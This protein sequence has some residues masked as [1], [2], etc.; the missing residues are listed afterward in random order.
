MNPLDNVTDV[1]KEAITHIDGPL[2]II[3]AAGSGKTRVITRRIAYLIENGV[4][5]YNILAI[6]FTNKA[7]NEMKER[8]NKFYPH[9]G[10]WVSTFHSMCARILRLEIEKLGYS[11]TFTIYDKQDQVSSIKE[12]IK[13]LAFDI[14]SFSPTKISNAISNAKNNLVSPTEFKE[15]AS[16]YYD[17]VVSQVYLKY[18]ELLKNN[19]ALDFDDLQL[20]VVELFKNFS[21]V[22][23]NYQNK[24]KYILIDEYQD[25]NRTQYTIASLLSQNHMNI[26]VTGDPDQS[27]YSWRGADIQNILD[28]E[29]DY[30]NTKTV[31]LEQ[32]YRSTKTILHAASN[33]IINNTMR[34]SK[35]LWTENPQGEK[36]DVIYSIDE[37][38]EAD[39]IREHIQKLSRN[40]KPNY[41]D[42]AIFYRTNAQSRVIEE[43]LRNNSIPYIIVGSVEFYRRKEIK[44]ILAYLKL[45]VNDD[46]DIATARIINVPTRG[47][48]KVSLAKITNWAH[49]NN[50]SVLNAILQ[51]TNNQEN[52]NA[53]NIDSNFLKG[54]S[55]LSIEQFAGIMKKL[56]SIKNRS[57]KDI[58]E[59]T[60]KLTNY[61]KFLEVSEGDKSAD[62]IGNVDELVNAANEY[63]ISYP[64]GSLA[65]FLENVSLVSDIDSW[66]DNVNAVTLMTLHSAKGLEFPIVFLTGLE[67]GLLPHSQSKDSLH[68]LEEERRLCY[69]GITR[70]QKELILTYARSRFRNGERIPAPA[71]QFIDEIPK[72]IIEFTDKTG[73]TLTD[74]D[75][76]EIED[77]FDFDEFDEE[78]GIK[79]GDAVRHKTFG[80]GRVREISG[81]GNTAKAKISFNVGGTKSLMI[82]YAK[83]EKI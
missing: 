45:C 63:D 81:Y 51:F 44:D 31:K 61:K 8:V 59:N 7:A 19:N 66:D 58:V 46:D 73:Y 13:A 76:F 78:I 53:E 24:F 1:Q 60:I 68:G 12:V 65:G 83:L 38:Q 67:D 3:A 71:S 74:N 30:P 11:N 52:S 26:C 32:N 25:T 82:K 56:Q 9:K 14:T 28:F 72:D 16:G 57:V 27:I 29:N 43:A 6:T 39:V 55:K 50:L 62:K 10:M 40:K 4:N 33:I 5:P 75:D 23:E 34:K 17:G 2:L 64:E 54:K 18:D 22:L 37:N 69:V 79:P 80:I 20:K 47:I 49:D 36:I 15:T 77:E 42:I 21:D 41:S 35:G 48:G 70:A